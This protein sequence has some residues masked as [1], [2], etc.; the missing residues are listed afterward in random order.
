M[1]AYN[2]QW[3]T[4]HDDKQA[5]L[6]EL[7]LLIARKVKKQNAS[8]LLVQDTALRMSSE[9]RDLALGFKEQLRK[10]EMSYLGECMLLLHSRLNSQQYLSFLFQRGRGFQ[11]KSKL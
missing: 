11:E 1:F 6:S 8:I 2:A 7:K 10:P 3:A 9:V 5:W 4:S